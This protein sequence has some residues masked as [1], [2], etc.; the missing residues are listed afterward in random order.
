MNPEQ[1]I[2]SQPN[3]TNKPDN[4]M[5]NPETGDGSNLT[6]PIIILSVSGIGLSGIFIYLR[7]RKCNR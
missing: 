6:L 3:D 1:M 7:K 4:R 2:P 5:D